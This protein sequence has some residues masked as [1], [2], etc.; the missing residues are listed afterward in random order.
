MKGNLTEGNIGNQQEGQTDLQL[1]AFKYMS[2]V[3]I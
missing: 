1:Y 3:Y 2:E